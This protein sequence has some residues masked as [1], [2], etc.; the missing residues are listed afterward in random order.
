MTRTLTQVPVWSWYCDRCAEQGGELAWD[1]KGL[2]SPDEMR[3]R[4][5][6]IAEKWGDLCPKC[7]AKPW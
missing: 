5:W 4:G 1:Q 3:A 7:L 6:F 2:P